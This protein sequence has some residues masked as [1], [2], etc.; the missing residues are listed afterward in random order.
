MNEKKNLYELAHQIISGDLGTGKDIWNNASM[1][2]YSKE[3]IDE[4]EKISRTTS[5]DKINDKHNEYIGG[6]MT[7][8][9]K[10]NKL[11]RLINAV[12]ALTAFMPGPNNDNPV[13]SREFL[14]KFLLGFTNDEYKEN[15]KLLKREMSKFKKSNI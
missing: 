6:N 7:E 5:W 4:A 11:N 10:N 2:G 3:E 12:N 15:E 14:F 1:L 13:I 8:E 9:E